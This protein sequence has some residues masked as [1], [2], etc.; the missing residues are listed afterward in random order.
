[1]SCCTTL[2]AISRECGTGIRP[3]LA[4]TVYVV[5][6][7]EI[8]TIPAD[9]GTSHTIS[10]DITL[11]TGKQFFAWDISQLNSSYIC[12]P[13][14]HVDARYYKTTIQFFIP[15]LAPAKTFILGGITN[16]EFICLVSDAKSQVRLI[17]DTARGA[18]ISA[19]EQTNDKNGY[20]VTIEWES[21]EPPFYY[22]GTIDVTGA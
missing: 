22:T 18:Y 7:D 3:G 4:T 5:C 13:Q 10:D 15:A 14:G 8:D 11:A 17:G 21:N 12:E 9:N 19:Q 6:K 2:A 1:M 16:G 20:V